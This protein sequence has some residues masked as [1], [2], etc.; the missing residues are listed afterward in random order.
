MT[1]D[2]AAI[3]DQLGIDPD[4]YQYLNAYY[5]ETLGIEEL[6]NVVKTHTLGH[7]WIV[8][9]TTNGLVGANTATEGG[10]QQTV[11]GGGRVKTIQRIV[12][13]NK[14]FN[15]HFRDIDFMDEDSTN[16]AHWDIVLFRL[17]MANSSDHFRA[18]NTIA[19]TSAIFYN[20]ETV[21]KARL[22]CVETK[23]AGDTII[24]YLSA[25]GGVSWEEV[26]L[27]ESHSFTN[28]GTDLR[29]RIMFAGIG[30]IDT[31]IED[32]KVSYS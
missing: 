21:T 22:D 4:T 15:E 14:V 19:T 30:G 20:S 12:N 10:E 11:G 5:N 17:A 16:T 29:V 1:K 31:Y 3:R 26:E 9:S 13:P 27:G 23:F 24:Y 6:A 18:Y 2:T 8:G 25:D 32:L 28:T 7:A